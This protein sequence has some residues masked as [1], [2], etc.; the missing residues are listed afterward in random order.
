[1]GFI[2]AFI[3][4]PARARVKEGAETIKLVA[5]STSIS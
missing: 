3:W 4:H 2:H 5:D 1:V